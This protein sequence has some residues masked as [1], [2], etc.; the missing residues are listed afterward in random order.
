MILTG[1]CG[2][3]STTFFLRLLDHF[4]LVDATEEE[5]RDNSSVRLNFFPPSPDVINNSCELHQQI[6]VLL[7]KQARSNA[8]FHHYKCLQSRVHDDMAPI[9]EA[10][11][12]KISCSAD[13]RLH[14]KEKDDELESIILLWFKFS[15]LKKIKKKIYACVTYVSQKLFDTLVWVVQVRR[16]VVI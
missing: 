8:W 10:T 6:F 1:E 2:F 9:Q 13:H 11:H 16:F 15:C 14:Q 12:L 4:L 7:L 5:N 3:P